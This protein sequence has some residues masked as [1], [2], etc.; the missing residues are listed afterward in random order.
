MPSTAQPAALRAGARLDID[1]AVAHSRTE[2]SPEVALDF[3][4]AVQRAFARIARHPA[5]GS[6]L[7][8]LELALPVLRSGPIGRFPYTVFFVTRADGVDVWRVLHP[9]RDVP[10]W[11]HTP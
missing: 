6:P 5:I 4:D 2:A 3:I 9:Q 11:M 8:G 7:I 1:E 10:R